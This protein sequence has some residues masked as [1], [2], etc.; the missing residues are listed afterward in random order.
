MR[1][2]LPS[3][4]NS[5][6]SKTSPT[7][8][9]IV[10][11]LSFTLIF[12]SAFQATANNIPR[13]IRGNS[14]LFTDQALIY[15]AVSFTHRA[16]QTKLFSVWTN[17]LRYVSESPYA[18]LFRDPDEYGKAVIRGYIK[19]IIGKAR[20]GQLNVS[21]AIELIRLLR[22]A[23]PGVIDLLVLFDIQVPLEIA[24][25]MFSGNPWALLWGFNRYERSQGHP[26]LHALVKGDAILWI[27]SRPVSTAILL[28]RSPVR[29][30][31]LLIV[32]SI[33]PGGILFTLLWI[34]FMER[35]LGLFLIIDHFREKFQKI[36]ER[37]QT[38]STKVLPR[39]R[40]AA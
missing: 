4:K 1:S 20:S 24:S 40:K 9:L 29:F 2:F 23:H 38:I 33:V 21:Y 22:K 16:I 26:Y 13:S 36:S 34:R 37:L 12:T 5:K 30:K 25:L 32:L 18:H 11:F 7:H 27:L 6:P 15:P 31:A 3:S 39:S 8:R 35:E 19:K 17:S 28:W 10:L 14:S